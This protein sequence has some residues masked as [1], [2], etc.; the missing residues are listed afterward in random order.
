MGDVISFSG[1][2]TDGQDGRPGASALS[3][4]LEVRHCPSTCHTHPLQTFAGVASGSF[5]APDHSYPSYLRLRLTATDSGGL[6][7]TRNLRLD[8]RTVALRFRTR[9]YGLALV[10]G[11]DRQRATFRRTVIVGSTNS[12]SAVSPQSR[13]GRKYRFVSWSDRGAQTHDLTAPGA[14]RTYTARFR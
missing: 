12:V 7:R 3:W 14:R 13:R 4:A 5:T 10:V 11:G 6:S 9:P 8:P 2:A 1:S